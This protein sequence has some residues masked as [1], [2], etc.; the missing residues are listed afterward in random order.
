MEKLFKV[1]IV[2]SPGDEDLLLGKKEG[3]SLSEIFKLENIKYEYY[4]VVSRKMFKEAI[5]LIKNDIIELKEE[6]LWV[7]PIIHLS[8][9]GN[10]ECICMSNGTKIEWSY[11]NNIIGDINDVFSDEEKNNIL[12]C[13]SSCY[14]L[15]AINA[16]KDEDDDDSKSPFSSLIGSEYEISWEDSLIAFSVFYHNYIIKEKSMIKSIVCMNSSI[17]E[18]GVFKRRMSIDNTIKARTRRMSS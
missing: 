12:L 7:F 17:G 9:H 4:L 3:D 10:D 1:Y 15:Y 5:Q 13:M 14:G 8:C 18:D 6:G 16:D 11:L 2:E